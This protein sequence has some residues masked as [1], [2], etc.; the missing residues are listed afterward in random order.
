MLDTAP[1]W[2][3]N[4]KYFEFFMGKK[5]VWQNLFLQMPEKVWNLALFLFSSLTA[6]LNLIVHVSQSD[7]LL[8]RHSG[9]QRS[10]SWLSP[11]FLS[12]IVPYPNFHQDFL[13]TSSCPPQ[14][15]KY[16]LYRAY[17][18]KIF[19]KYKKLSQPFTNQKKRLFYDLTHPFILFIQGVPK[20][21]GK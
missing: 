8:V 17:Y 2:S 20:K 1:N 5:W 9:R 11:P 12:V 3:M 14:T 6:S 15:R 19:S 18:L 10:G 21:R 16:E 7:Q 4:C 13:S